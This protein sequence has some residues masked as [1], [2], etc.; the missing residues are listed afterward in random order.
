MFDRV[1][2]AIEREF[3]RVIDLPERPSNRE[4]ARAAIEA[5]EPTPSMIAAAPDGL[6]FA[7]FF[8]ECMKGQHPLGPNTLAFQNPPLAEA[9]GRCIAFIAKA[10]VGDSDRASAASV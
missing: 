8:D 2:R 3:D 5:M 7:L 10:T 9:W 1:A 6:A 4:L